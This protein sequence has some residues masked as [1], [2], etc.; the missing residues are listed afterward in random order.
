MKKDLGN[1]DTNMTRLNHPAFELE[2]IVKH[3]YPL[4]EIPE[5]HMNEHPSTT[6]GPGYGPGASIAS[7]V[8]ALQ[9][10][11][12]ILFDSS[13]QLS[14]FITFLTTFVDPYAVLVA[15]Y[16]YSSMIFGLAKCSSFSATYCMSFL[17]ILSSRSC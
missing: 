4:I 14:Y 1:C 6:F 12:H 13:F 8:V 2:G 10:E 17:S 9:I 11:T 5:R 7:L 15:M 3:A 16:W